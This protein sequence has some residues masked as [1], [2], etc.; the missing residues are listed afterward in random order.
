ME[1]KV[2]TNIIYGGKIYSTGELVDI[3]EKDIAERCLKTK[4]IS[5]NITEEVVEEV[6][7]VELEKEEKTEKPE[8]KKNKKTDKK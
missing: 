6:T 1:Y 8:T 3:E 5:E 2:L 4:L 7:E